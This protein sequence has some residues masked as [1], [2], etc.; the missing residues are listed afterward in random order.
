LSRALEMA[1]AGQIQDAKTL[2]GLHLLERRLRRGTR[3]DG[4]T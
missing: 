2:I 1:D 3:A 4:P